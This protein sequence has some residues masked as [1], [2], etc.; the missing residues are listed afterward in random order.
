MSFLLNVSDVLNYTG[1]F[2]RKFIEG[3]CACTYF[4]IDRIK[5]NAVKLDFLPVEGRKSV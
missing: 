2:S 3:I 5:F 4:F 1:E